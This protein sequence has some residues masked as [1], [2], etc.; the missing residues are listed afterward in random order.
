M[1]ELLWGPE[2]SATFGELDAT[3]AKAKLV[4]RLN[5]ALDMLEENPG[6]AVCRRHRFQNIGVWGISAVAAGEEWMILWEPAEN[7]ED[8]VIH[9]IYQLQ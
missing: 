4:D 2:A 1:A 7:P 5:E 8:V 9:A 6:D 3:P